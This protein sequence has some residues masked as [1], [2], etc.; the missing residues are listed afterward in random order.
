V[1]TARSGRAALNHHLEM[2]G[3]KLDKEKLDEVY[4]EFLLLADKKK[5]IKE[6]DLLVLVGE[7]GYSERRIKLDFLQVVTG[8]NLIPMATLRLDIAG[9]KFTATESG[10]GPVDAAIKAVKDIIH[11]KVTLQEFLIQAINKGSDDIGKVH[12]QVEHDGNIFN[13]FGANTDII[14]ASVEAFIDAIN[15]IGNSEKA[16]DVEKE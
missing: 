10:N 9:E 16:S 11:R 8:K 2:L 4:Q 5:D 12:M 7:R 1:L 6:D 3:V 15:K 14:T 13:G